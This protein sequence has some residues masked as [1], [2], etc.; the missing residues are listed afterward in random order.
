MPDHWITTTDAARRLGVKRETLYAYVSRGLL[1]S[2]R[3]PGQAESLFER[4]Q[5]EALASGNG[6]GRRASESLLRFRAVS[7]AVS[8]IHEGELYLRG[9]SVA[10][11]CTSMTFVE[12]ARFVLQCDAPAV[13]NP[14]ARKRSVA[15]I[16]MARRIPLAVAYLGAL[17]PLR[18]EIGSLAVAAKSISLIE[19]L[20]SL[21]PEIDFDDPWVQA[22]LIC[23]ID[24]GLAASTT[25]ARVAASARAGLYDCLLAGYGALSGPLHGAAPVQAFELI[26]LIVRGHSLDEAIGQSVD[27][28]GR[29]PGFGHVVYRAD[30]PRALVLLELIK[31]SHRN[32]SQ[33]RAIDQ[34]R[35]RSSAPMNID[36]VT[37]AALHVLGLPAKAGEVLFQIGRTVGMSAHVIEEYSEQPLR[38]RANNTE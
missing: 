32:S 14:L 29:L 25:A 17:D 5:V 6:S 24:N 23:L 27:R 21:F 37:A 19:Y 11:L 36:I 2:K 18:S 4:T 22:I 28:Y 7:T 33:V 31:I 8:R 12:A 9:R 34:L 38:W 16:A 10:D 30:D 3:Q 15:K 20:M 26:D 13:R 35:K 1:R